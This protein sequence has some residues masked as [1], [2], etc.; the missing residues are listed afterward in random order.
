MQRK[1]ADRATVKQPKQRLDVIDLELMFINAIVVCALVLVI[2]AA[3][4]LMS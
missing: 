2:V 4:I 3:D 1:Q